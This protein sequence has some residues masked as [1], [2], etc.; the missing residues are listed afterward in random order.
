MNR[1]IINIFIVCKFYTVAILAQGEQIR[2]FAPLATSKA[3]LMGC[4]SSGVSR[5]EKIPRKVPAEQV[6]DPV[7]TQDSGSPT[8]SASVSTLA[9]RMAQTEPLPLFY[10]HNRKLCQICKYQI[11][12]FGQVPDN[13]VQDDNVCSFC[14]RALN[15]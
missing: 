8:A 7:L 6:Y 4:C 2:R 10:Q 12:A 9:F 14:A 3:F 13:D 15:G 1:Y 5:V 11:R